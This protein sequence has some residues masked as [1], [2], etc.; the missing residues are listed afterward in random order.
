MIM[1]S[2]EKTAWSSRHLRDLP[3]PVEA[4]VDVTLFANYYGTLQKSHQFNDPALYTDKN[5]F[6]RLIEK[7]R[8]IQVFRRNKKA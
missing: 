6:V 4:N 8:A 5:W 7:I 1:N 3:P 2:K